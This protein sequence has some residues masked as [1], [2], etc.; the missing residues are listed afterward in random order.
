MTDT[1]AIISLIKAEK[2][3]NVKLVAITICNGNTSTNHSTRNALLTLEKFGRL[4]IPVFV[5]AE[6]ALINKS[7][8]PKYHGEDGLQNIY[9]DKPDVSLLQK[10]HAV[11]AL[12][13]LIEKV[14]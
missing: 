14:R 11:I 7:S 3:L 8:F 13:E 9:Q 1:W 2:K 5:G 10:K 12:S 6:S 4:D